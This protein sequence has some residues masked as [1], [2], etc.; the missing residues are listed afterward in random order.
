MQKNTTIPAG[1]I[2]L[3]VAHD[4]KGMVQQISAL[5]KMLRTNLQAFSTD[6]TNRIFDYMELV[7]RQGEAITSDLLESGE[8]EIP[9]NLPLEVLSLN[10]LI[11]EQAKM[12]LLHAD[13]KGITFQLFL[14]DKQFFFELNQSKFIRALDNLFFN[15]LRFTPTKGNIQIVLA[16]KNGNAGIEISDTGSGIPEELQ[17]DIFKKYSRAYNN[18]EKS[19]TGLGLYITKKIIELHRGTIG[20][21][22]GKTG[23][24]FFIELKSGIIL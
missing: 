4:F 20:F 21:S 9:S 2:L 18:Q 22:T 3:L 16:P 8:L 11:S 10:N 7:C 23:T 5:N 14:P 6:E 15:A 17:P 1:D 13:A 19:Q 12:Y 24:T